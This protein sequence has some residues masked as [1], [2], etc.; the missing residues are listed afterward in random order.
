MKAI[1]F[2]T[3]LLCCCI[4]YTHSTAQSSGS[5]IQFEN[6]QVSI[7][8]ETLDC[9]DAS[10]GTAKQ[11]LSLIVSN[12]LDQPISVSFKREMWY[13]SKCLNCNSDS[14][15]YISQIELGANE[16]KTGDCSSSKQLLIFS[17]MLELKGV[18]ELTHFEIK[19]INI[20]E[21]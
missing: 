2:F 7:S 9:I 8:T 3:I 16:T 18:R 20:Q 11:C 17:K 19:N 1:R 10:K 14:K 13:G 5:E 12:K 4:I 6:N 15:E 21:L